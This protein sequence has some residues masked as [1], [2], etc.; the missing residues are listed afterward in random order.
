MGGEKEFQCKD[1]TEGLGSP[2]RGRGKVSGKLTRANCARITP[3]WA[4]KRVCPLHRSPWHRDHPRVGGEKNLSGS[5]IWE[6]RG[7]PPRGR[8]KA[9]AMILHIRAK[10]I[11]PAWAGKSRDHESLRP[12]RQDHPRVGGEKSAAIFR[13]SGSWGS[14]PRGRGKDKSGGEGGTLR[15]I[16]PAWAGK[17]A[18][19]GHTAAVKQD[20]PR[21]GGEKGGHYSGICAGRGSPPRGRGKD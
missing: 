20:H 14:P 6:N 13:S 15:R 19:A 4:G 11:T 5:A 10:G 12:R 8:G 1:R 9:F 2:P 7:S 17:S 18:P 3:A 16:T 21:V